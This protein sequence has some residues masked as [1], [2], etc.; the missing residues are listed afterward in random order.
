MNPYETLGIPRD[1]TEDQIEDAYDALF[2]QYEP[3]AQGGDQPSVDMLNALNEARDVLLDPT[4]RA[5]LDAN[6]DRPRRPAP[7]Q[8]EA[9]PRRQQPQQQARQ[10]QAQRPPQQTAPQRERDAVQ[11]AARPQNK[12]GSTTVKT[13]RRASYALEP[14]VPKRDLLGYWPY[15]IVII[16]LA[17]AIAFGT[18][19]L[20]SKGSCV[21]ADLPTGATVATVNGTPI[22]QRE[23]DVRERIDKS[24]ALS[25]PLF[26]S[27]FD[28]TTITGTRALDTLKFDSLDKLVN[29]QVIMQQAKKE[30]IW[31]TED[32]ANEL[33][34]QAAATDEKP[35]ESYEALLCRLQVS[36]NKYR[37]TVVEN[38]IY[39][40]MAD[41]HMPKDG[42]DN[43]R[44]DGFIKWICDT[45]SAY[46]VQILM[47]FLVPNNPPCTSG[48]PSDVPLPGLSQATPVPEDI[49]TAVAPAQPT[50][51]GPSVPGPEATTAP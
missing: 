38:V 20:A 9:A 33:V 43:K 34:Q 14:Q 8:Q 22:Y 42:D 35:G 47:D 40:V 31:P 36:N 1:A 29:M 18:T 2:D 23:L 37:Q 41:H 11:R 44:T 6:L 49:P 45:R 7:P 13:R 10:Q 30:G 51:T 48:L 21:P 3:L 17:G 25:D 24:G 26:S 16:V 28:P 15:Y 46:D 12:S 19:F 39:T 50:A 4:R 32:Q 27:F 5:R